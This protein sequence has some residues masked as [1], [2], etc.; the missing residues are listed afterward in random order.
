MS[1][2]SLEAAVLGSLL[3]TD[4][5][6]YK[7]AHLLGGEL[8]SSPD[9]RKV[10]NSIE[11]VAN[12][13]KVDIITVTEQMKKDKTLEQVGGPGYITQL[14]D[15]IGSTAHFE[16]HLLILKQ[17]NMTRGLGRI[18]YEVEKQI[19]D[20]IDPHDIMD[21]AQMSLTKIDQRDFHVIDNMGAALKEFVDYY[22]D[23]KTMKEKL[24]P[25]GFKGVDDIIVGF[26]KSD[27]VIIA[28]APSMGKTALAINYLDKQLEVGRKVFFSSLEMNKRQIMGR[29]VCQKAGVGLSKL[30]KRE[31]TQEE[32]DNM[33]AVMERLIDKSLFVDDRNSTLRGLL[34]TIRMLKVKENIDIVIVD[35]L[36]LISNTSRSKNRQEEVSGIVREL[37]NISR[38][39]D[40]VTVALSQLSREGY[41]TGSRPSLS[42]LRESGEI[43]QA[44]DT[45]I[46]P[47]RPDYFDYTA[48]SNLQESEII[49]A[50]GRN[51][52]TGTTKMMFNREITKFYE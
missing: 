49:I 30:R 25:T 21:Y 7:H 34:N 29:L 27:L 24:M 3:L 6:Y 13:S 40:I 33:N 28:G 44:A 35:Y 10:Y 48:N 43:E 36:Q 50:K 19:N 51:A 37:K 52:G 12:T 32:K 47:F 15:Q 16:Q 39:L 41:R 4:N 42:D 1:E 23:D 2:E 38:E 45:I 18:A 5:L 14:I 11:K 22:S 46:F 8:F 31:T 26:E 20:K 9:N 17:Y